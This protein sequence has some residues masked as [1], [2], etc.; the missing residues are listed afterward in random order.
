MLITIANIDVKLSKKSF[1]NDAYL[2][3]GLAP[4]ALS[5][6]WIAKMEQ[7]Y[8]KAFL[9]FPNH[10]IFKEIETLYFDKMKEL[11]RKIKRP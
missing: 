5:E 10:K 11:K 2:K 4:Y 9:L 3:A 1:Y 6:A 8:K 7:I